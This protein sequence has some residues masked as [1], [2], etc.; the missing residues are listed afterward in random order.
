[1]RQVVSLDDRA[2]AHTTVGGDVKLYRVHGEMYDDGT[3][4]QQYR[5]CDG[6]VEYGRFDTI[7]PWFVLTRLDVDLLSEAL[8]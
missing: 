5:R 3:A 2:W 6:W 7:E 8:S 1:M 4:R